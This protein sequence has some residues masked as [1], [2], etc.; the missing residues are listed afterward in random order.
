MKRSDPDF[1]ELLGSARRS[2][3]HLEMRDGYGLADEVE[4]FT[5]WRGGH[6]ANRADRSVWWNPF[7]DAVADADAD[8][9]AVGR[10]P[11]CGRAPRPDRLRS[12]QRVHP[13]RALPDHRERDGW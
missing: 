13:V 6:R 4:D 11:W 9:D 3:V 5:A 10:G 2:A 1:Y 8:A 12:G 7:H